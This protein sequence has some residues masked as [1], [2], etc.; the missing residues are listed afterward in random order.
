MSALELLDH[1][2][3]HVEVAL[4][5]PPRGD[6]VLECARRVPA[7]LIEP[8]TLCRKQPEAQ[9]GELIIGVDA[10]RTMAVR[11][12]LGPDGA[13]RLL[14]RTH[15]SV[16]VEPRNVL[17]RE[18]ELAEMRLR[19]EPGSLDDGRQGNGAARRH[20]KPERTDG[21]ASVDGVRESARQPGDR[22]G[23][24]QHYSGQAAAVEPPADEREFGIDLGP[25]AW[26][27]GVG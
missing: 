3:L 18:P 4:A 12:K 11:R 9:C 19:L 2:G 6:G 25:H 15:K 16:A 1:A 10:E 7:E 21:I 14:G 8:L 13:R 23:P 20:N 17:E 27:R 5:G 24:R 26:D 22:S